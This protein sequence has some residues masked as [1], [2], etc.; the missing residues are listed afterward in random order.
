MKL[1]SSIAKEINDSLRGEKPILCHFV[2]APFGIQPLKEAV[3]STDKEC[4]WCGGT[5]HHLPL[6]DPTKS[7]ERTWLCANIDCLV[8]KGSNDIWQYKPKGEGKR[9]LLWPLFCEIN[10]IGDMN[11][12]VRF[13]DIKQDPKKV[14]YLEK[15][16]ESP[17][18]II[19]MQGQKGLGKTFAA[20]A[21]CELFTRKNS[22]CIFITHKQLLSV[23][24]QKDINFT[25]KIEGVSLVVIDDF[26]TGE[27]T[28]GFLN[29]FMDLINTRI[30]WRSR[31]TI[32]TTNLEDDKLS[33]FCGEALL[34]RILTGMNFVF[35][36]NS[37]RKK[38]IL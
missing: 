31:G 12:D 21:T 29:Y 23:W 27:P 37:R 34:D 19:L 5:S 36:G 28:P 18:G 16:A 24:L 33:I 26:G 30:Q 3:M 38:N 22:S 20:L 9:A 4:E 13:E 35:E 32:I 15:F 17:K 6:I 10:G 14:A 7:S 11:H 2:T 8:Y 1:I 25:N